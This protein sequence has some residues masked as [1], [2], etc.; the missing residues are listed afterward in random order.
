MLSPK[1][2]I[3]NVRIP[4]ELSEDLAYLCGVIAG[5]GHINI[6]LEKHDWLIKC[7]GNP[8]DEISFYNEV[9]GPLF[10][11]LFGYQPIMRLQDCGETYGFCTWSRTIVEYLVNVGLPFGK[12]YD[13]LRIPPEFLSYEHLTAAF[14]RGVADTDFH[15][16][17]KRGSKKR[18][19]YPTI[20]GCSKSHLFIIEI[21]NWL[22][23]KGIKPRIAQFYS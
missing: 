18:P 3:K 7:V 2:K 1:D 16:G 20:V 11:K 14:I 9:I 21:G 13:K 8:K 23:Q 6:R 22:I 12:K 17:L 5:D 19:I 10:L 15:L 4:F